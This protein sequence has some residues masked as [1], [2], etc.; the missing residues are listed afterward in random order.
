MAKLIT[1]PD[2]KT[3]I[4]IILSFYCNTSKGV[5]VFASLAG[6]T[7]VSEPQAKNLVY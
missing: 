1:N 3:K 2:F 4:E 5:A 6:R 7:K